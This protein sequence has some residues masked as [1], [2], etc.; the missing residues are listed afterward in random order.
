MID[1]NDLEKNM[2]KYIKNSYRLPD[3]QL[4]AYVESIS[5]RSAEKPNKKSTFKEKYRMN[6]SSSQDK[7]D[8]Y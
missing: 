2:K 1:K 8:N 7:F 6:P 3:L 5:Q 4:E